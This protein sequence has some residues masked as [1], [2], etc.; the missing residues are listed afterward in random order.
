MQVNLRSSDVGMPEEFLN[1]PQVGAAVQQ[2]G[3]ERVAEDMGC[4]ALVDARSRRRF[5]HRA[6]KRPVEGV[7]APNKT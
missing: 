6:L 1:S 3:G 7:V 2:M 4:H 5:T